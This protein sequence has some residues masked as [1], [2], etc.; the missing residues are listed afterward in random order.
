MSPFIVSAVSEVDAFRVMYG[1]KMGSKS[2]A[3]I[4]LANY[5][6]PRKGAPGYE[7]AVKMLTAL[8]LGKQI[9]VGKVIKVKG[10]DLVAEVYVNGRNIN[11][12]IN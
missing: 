3:F 11:E 9:H 1:W 10:K 4:R 8:V 6:G 5:H 12:F 7:K 2:G